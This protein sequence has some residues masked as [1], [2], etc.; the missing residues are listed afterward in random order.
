M[1]GWWDKIGASKQPKFHYQQNSKFS[2]EMDYN[3]RQQAYQREIDRILEK[4]RKRGYGSLT[5]E[6]KRKLFDASG[7]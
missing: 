3:A 6:E 2:D 4:V 7:R 5:E 1:Q